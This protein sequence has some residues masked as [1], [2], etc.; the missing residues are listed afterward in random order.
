[1]LFRSDGALP[2]K[3]VGE[4]QAAQ[5]ALLELETLSNRPASLMSAAMDSGITVKE[6]IQQET[7]QRRP[8]AQWQ[9]DT[10]SDRNLWLAK[11]TLVKDG[12]ISRELAIKFD[13]I[14]GSEAD[15]I[16]ALRRVGVPEEIKELPT[17]WLDSTVQRILA[18]AWLP[19]VLLLVAFLAI[20]VE[21]GTPGLGAGGFV[22]GL[23]FLGFFWIEAL[24]G[25]VEWLEVLL[26]V[27]GLIALAIEAFVLPGFGL[28][29]IG[30]FVMLLA[31]V[32][33]ASQTFIIPR[34][35]EQLSVVAYNFFWV[36]VSALTVM[37]GLL[38]MRKQIEASPMVRWMTLEP[39]GYEDPDELA[40]RE[41]IV[42][43]EHLVGQSGI[44]TTRLNPA[45]KAQFGR[46]IVNVLGSGSMVAEGQVVRVIEVRGNAVIVEE[47]V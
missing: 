8:L 1:M 12:D 36:S 17:P 7:G 27:G 18:Q 43:W 6:Y 45:G 5:E 37:I 16:A 42:H 19:R 32:V 22:A 21:L 29:G 4:N 9:L 47:V 20:S 33:L 34:N 15:V 28:F 2:G 11:D 26:F 35:S 46:Q 40:H 25:N 3:L 10:L 13:L 38:M 23:C 31:S 39:S 14:T 24:N 44:T 30:G 41:S